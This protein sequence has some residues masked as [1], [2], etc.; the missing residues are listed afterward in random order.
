MAETKVQV[1]HSLMN[2]YW[3]VMANQH[4][5]SQMSKLGWYGAFANNNRFNVRELKWLEFYVW[6]NVMWTWHKKTDLS[7][8][9]IETIFYWLKHFW[10]TSMLHVQI[11]AQYST[12]RYHNNKNSR[13]FFFFIFYQN[14]NQSYFLH[15]GFLSISLF[16]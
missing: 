13:A 10:L 3:W 8:G 2:D 4:L 7:I 1:D 14:L 16:F 11:G 12:N 15:L 5:A 6:L 9:T